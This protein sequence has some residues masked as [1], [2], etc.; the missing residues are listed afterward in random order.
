M[1]ELFGRP[2][3][4]STDCTPLTS[5]RLR[6]DIVT[7]SVG[8]FRVTGFRPAVAA[9]RRIFERVRAEQGPLYRQLGTTGMLCVRAIRGWSSLYSNHSWGMAIDITIS[10]HVVPQ[11]SAKT[12]RGLLSLYPY[13]HAE[14]FYWG[15][16][17][18]GNRRDPMHFEASA[19]LVREWA[20]D[21]APAQVSS[22]GGITYTPGSPIECKPR[23]SG[24]FGLRCTGSISVD[25]STHVPSGTRL[26]L[27]T[28][29]LF[30]GSATASQSPP[31]KL[32]FLLSKDVLSCPP[33]QTTIY[34]FK[35]P[36][37]TGRPIATLSGLQIDVECP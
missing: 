36:L 7:E 20:R 28:D 19:E 5:N 13:F 33:A 9:V 30:V 25:I 26:M 2:G 4:L 21:V 31:G 17:F 11:G 6:K 14:R 8:P 3:R 18:S 24:G 12:S 29:S 10:R 35:G 15:A 22:D 32:T 16:G 27:T 1:L 23:P 34:L 37:I